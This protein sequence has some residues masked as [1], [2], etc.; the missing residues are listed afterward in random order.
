MP[1]YEI[2]Y[3]DTKKRLAGNIC[4]ECGDDR[5]AAVFAFAM[6]LR[7][8]V[9]VEV[10]CADTLVCEGAV[11]AMRATT[12]PVPI[13]PFQL[14]RSTPDFSVRYRAPTGAARAARP[15]RS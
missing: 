7:N 15:S 14:R 4:T 10:W 1:I 5:E 6:T 9:R 8:A 3:I 11:Q 12:T 13:A 2:C